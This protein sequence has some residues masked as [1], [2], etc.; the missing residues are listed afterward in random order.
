[1]KY[2]LGA[3][4]PHCIP[5]HRTGW[6]VAPFIVAACLA[7]VTPVM[8]GNGDDVIT[9]EGHTDEVLAVAV[10]PDG[11]RVLTGSA[12]G[13]AR[14]WNA[15]TGADLET[16]DELDGL[17]VRAVAFVLHEGEE[18]VLIG[19]LEITGT[20]PSEEK[21]ATLWH[22]GTEDTSTFSVS[23]IGGT[24]VSGGVLALSADGTLVAVGKSSFQPAPYVFQ[25][26]VW[27]VESGEELLHDLDGSLDDFAPWAT[28]LAFSPTGE[29]TLVGRNGGRI[30]VL[31]TDGGEVAHSFDAHTGR[32]AAMAPA[33]D[34]E[35][36]LTG[37]HDETAK[38][39]DA[40]GEEEELLRTMDTHGDHVLAVDIS[41]GAERILTAGADNRAMLWDGEE[42]S[43]MEI[44]TG[45]EDSITAAAFFPNVTHFVTGSLDGTARIWRHW[46]IPPESRTTGDFT[47]SGVTDFQDFNFLLENWGEQ[48][49][50]VPL[51][52]LD[53]I[54]MLENWG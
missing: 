20:F 7:T 8:A 2:A 49:D 43:L 34:A 35:L 15:G 41:A 42:W 33:A 10:S 26:K 31:V 37:S 51:G 1:M 18:H 45:H 4:D 9:L 23:Q 47:L 50:G 38:L 14:L 39:W 28:A 48:I 30:D 3:Q 13:T 40:A 44:F 5:L 24:G 17:A 19:G 12:D 46:K 16:F 21:T 52:F 54:A 6:N 29:H 11:T 25:V 53:F 32:V 36:L 27:E 22:S